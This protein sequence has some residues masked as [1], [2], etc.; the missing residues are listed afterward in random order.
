MGKI[1]TERLNIE[2]VPVGEIGT[3][4]CIIWN[5]E[6]K[7]GF[8]ADPGAWEEKIIRKLNETGIELR[9]IL[10]T[11]GH[12]DHIMAVNHIKEK[13]RA[14]VYAGEEEEELLGDPLLNASQV[15]GSP[16]IVSTPEHLV[17]EGDKIE[18]AGVTVKVIETPGHTIGSVCYYIEEE[19]ILLCGDT[20]FMES[21]GRTDLP[22]GSGSALLRSIR[23]KLAV[24]PDEVVA[25]PGHG[26]KTTIGY[27]KRNNPYMR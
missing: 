11:H 2:I 17:R 21:V 9:A 19:G 24:L 14:E 12:F 20:L 4:C 5:K 13:Y 26:P 23:E 8:L 22:T 27:E 10:L 3:N 6:T 7:E 1:E 16:Y 15:V 25:I 18:L